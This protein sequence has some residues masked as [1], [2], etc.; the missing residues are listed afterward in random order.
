MFDWANSV[1]SLVITSAIFPTYYLSVTFINSSDLVSFFGISIENSVLYSYALSFSFLVVALILP[2]LTGIADYTGK[3]KLFMKLFTF[4]GSFSCIGLYFFTGQNI[5][6]GII[7]SVLASIGYSGSLVFYNSF[8]P[9][10]ASEDKYD[11]VSAKGFSYGYFGSVLLLIFN[12]IMIYTPQSFGLPDGSIAARFS[13]LLVGIWWIGFAQISFNAL[14][15]N[16]YRRKPGKGIFTKGYKEIRKVWRSLEN[17]PN[18]K[19]FLGAFFFYNTG[20]QTFMY[21]AVLFG[22]KELT[23][24]ATKLIFTILLI[25]LVAMG[26]SYMFAKVSE[27]KGNKFALLIMIQ[28]WILVCVWAY[29]LTNEYQFYGLAFVIGIIMGGIQALSRA[30]YSKLI[31]ENTIDHASYFSFYDV[32]YNVS[33]VVGT[34]AYGFIEYI[35]GSMR[36]SALALGGFF[37]IGYLFLRLVQIPFSTNQESTNSD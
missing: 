35:T 10:I 32:T 31:P 33:I 28:I 18:L 30:T 22:T 3:K 23:L 15:S 26:G 19:K 4:L 37:I 5:E 12:L 24:E 2:L 11:I 8:L 20:V 9:E 14:P 21:L 27:F 29:F 7:L 17:L 13:F 25:Q 34:F 16:P 6:L 1:Y 36:L